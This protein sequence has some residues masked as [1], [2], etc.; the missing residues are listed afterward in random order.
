VKL[1][2]GILEYK[3][4]TPAKLK[5]KER[6]SKNETKTQAKWHELDAPSYNGLLLYEEGKVAHPNKPPPELE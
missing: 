4:T 6:V 2:P 3:M 5:Q 1:F